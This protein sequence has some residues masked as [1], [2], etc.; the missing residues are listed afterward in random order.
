M[1]LI[2]LKTIV[3]FFKKRWRL[4]LAAFLLGAIGGAGAFFLMPGKYLAEGN[5]YVTRR[6]EESEEFYTYSGYYNQ[7]TALSFADTVRGILDSRS[8]QSRVLENIDVKIDSANLRKFRRDYR[9]KN[10]GPR[11]IGIEYRSRDKTRA[12]MTWKVIVALIEGETDRINQQGDPLLRVVPLDETPLVR[13]TDRQLWSIALAGGFLIF[14]SAI[15]LSALT[16]T[17]EERQ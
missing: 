5:L 17:S 3:I 15:F 14:G 11:L 1:Q 9:I 4:W 2:E 6:Q 7:H 12:E 16:L 13:E 8:F 10:Q